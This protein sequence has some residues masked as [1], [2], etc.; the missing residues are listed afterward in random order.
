MPEEKAKEVKK[1]EEPK[2]QLVRVPTDYG[3]AIQ[4]PEG[5]T[6]NTDQAIVYLLNEI[7]ELRKVVG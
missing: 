1:E 7:M 5:E 4:T 3:L 2:F 6:M